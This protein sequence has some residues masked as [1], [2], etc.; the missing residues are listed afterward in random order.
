MCGDWDPQT[1]IQIPALLSPAL[2]LWATEVGLECFIYT[3][4]VRYRLSWR[5][6]DSSDMRT[7]IYL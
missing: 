2:E 7:P 6:T 4:A 1:Q 5:P 3:V